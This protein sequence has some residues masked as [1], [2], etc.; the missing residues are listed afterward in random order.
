MRDSPTQ[1]I[2]YKMITFNIS[3]VLQIDFKDQTF[4]DFSIGTF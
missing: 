2:Q 3:L 4:L 1:T